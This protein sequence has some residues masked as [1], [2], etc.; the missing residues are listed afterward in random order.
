[1]KYQ[2]W[3][4]KSNL[5][6]KPKIREGGINIIMKKAF[7][8]IL[9]VAVCVALIINTS[10][11]QAIESTFEDDLA[12]DTYINATTT[13]VFDINSQVPDTGKYYAPY[14]INS[15]YVTFNFT[16]DGDQVYTGGSSS[17]DTYGACDVVSIYTYSSYSYNDEGETAVVT[18]NDQEAEASSYYKKPNSSS[19]CS[20]SDID[21]SPDCASTG[22]ICQ[23]NYYDCVS[24]S[25]SGT[26]GNW[27]LV[28]NLDQTAIDDLATDGILSYDIF[29]SG[30]FNL[31]NATLTVDLNESND[32]PVADAGAGQTKHVGTV[33]TLDGSGS[34]D[35]DENYPLG[36]EWSLISVPIGSTAPLSDPIIVNPTFTPDLPG[37]YV[38]ALN[39][40]DSLGTVSEP[41]T[42]TISTTNTAPIAEAGDDQAIILHGTIIQLDDNSQSYDPDGDDITYQWAFV[43]KPDGSTASLTGADT[44]TP[45]FVADVHGVYEVEL[46][47][48][49]PWAQSLPDSVTVSF[50]NVAPVAD[51]G[52]GGIADL[53]TT[54]N[55]DGS[56]SFDANGDALGY[57]WSLTSV[58]TGSVAQ[59]IV[60][61]VVNPY[62]IPDVSGAYVVA[63]IVND[64]YLSSNTSS[65]Q[66]QV[67]M[68]PTAAVTII[69]RVAEVISSL[70][71]SVF[72]N[73]N[74]QNTLLNK[75]NA[76]VAN[77]EAGNYVDALAQL[78]NDILKKM[79]GCAESGSPDKNDW[80]R[81]CGSQGLIYQDM[82]DTIGSVEELL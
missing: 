26:T 15:A 48:N 56:L 6:H 51:A 66:I 41:A 47:V 74:M 53:F 44:A 72:K 78:Q 12:N 13:G 21:E 61:D 62:F 35:P 16:D 70:P 63:L 68:T 18:I 14:D 75:L 40:T 82:I 33:V 76:V 31:S 58:P 55:F 11:A 64:D 24:Y 3:R 73:K 39:V 22:C 81:D 38:V 52:T 80:I 23:Y 8:I 10:Q 50:D 1:M 5:K 54:V 25:Y 43:L 4:K 65:I 29:P 60:P 28:I 32:P 57:S 34:S 37:D 2:V 17:S 7:I 42:V 49:D 27:Q 79:N 59:I 67:I 36:Y 77:I 46:I 69:R 19:G 45:A 30:D 71:Q 9:T 20:L